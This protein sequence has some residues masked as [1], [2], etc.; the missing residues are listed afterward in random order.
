PK[1]NFTTLVRSGGH[2]YQ[3]K[4]SSCSSFSTKTSSGCG[5]ASFKAKG[6]ITD[7]TDPLASILIDSNA[8]LQVAVTDVGE[9]GNC[10]SLSLSILN[11]S[12]ALWFSSNLVGSKT[13]KQVLS[14]GNIQVRG[15]ST[16]MPTAAR[17]TSSTEGG[18]PAVSA[19]PVA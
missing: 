10:D 2:V 18:N 17:P 13:V 12:S 14:A 15:G 8:T 16:S 1:G 11:S 5:T 7:I 4:S 9:P 19:L 3:V 6:S